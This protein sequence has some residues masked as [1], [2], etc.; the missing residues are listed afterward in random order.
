MK[1]ISSWSGGK[2]SCLACYKAMQHGFQITHLLTCVSKEYC[3][4]SAHGL[5]PQLI[6]MQ[7]E[8]LGVPLLQQLVST[9]NY[10]KQFIAALTTLMPMGVKG[11]VFGDIYLRGLKNWAAEICAKIG[12]EALEPLWKMDPEKIVCEFLDADF[13]AVIIGADAKII[14]KEWIG[15]KFDKSFL[16]YLRKKNIDLCGENGEY[17]TLVTAGPIFSKKIEIKKSQPVLRDDRWFLDITE[18]KLK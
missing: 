17:H 5:D 11:V 18:F 12:I 10:E 15:A 9:K 16:Q 8:A 13:A 3:R 6:C 7:A 1:Y 4:V 14:D 2:D